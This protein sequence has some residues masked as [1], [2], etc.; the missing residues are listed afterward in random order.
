MEK[1]NI[2]SKKDYD[3]INQLI[4]QGGKIWED[5]NIK[6]LKDRIKRILREYQDQ[7]CCYCKR[8][9]TGEFNLVID[10]EHILPKSK[11]EDLMFNIDNL[12]ISCKKC[13]MNVKKDDLSFIIDL[14]AI[15]SNPFNK[16]NYRFIHPNFDEYYKCL[17]RIAIEVNNVR[18]VKYRVISDSDKGKFTYN[19]FR[20][21][22]FEQD[23]LNKAQGLFDKE[24]I[25]FVNI[26]SMTADE[27]WKLLFKKAYS[28]V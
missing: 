14:K 1:D 10:I 2:L 23:D 28:S 9:L 24:D 21:S 22:E 4:K 7:T 11:Y 18:F 19:Y 15:P 3:L 5:E 17:E 27:I 16:D 20:L 12:A 8:N 26:G 6:P 25:D 13:N